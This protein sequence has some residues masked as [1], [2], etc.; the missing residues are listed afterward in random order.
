MA[1][2]FFFRDRELRHPVFFGVAN[3]P[4]TALVKSLKHVV[5]IRIAFVRV[6]CSSR[7]VHKDASH[8]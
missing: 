8:R 4:F 2:F 5:Y 1:S 7:G 3:A 6:W